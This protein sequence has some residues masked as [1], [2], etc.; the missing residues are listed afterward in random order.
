MNGLGAVDDTEFAT[1]ILFILCPQT[2]YT[3]SRKEIRKWTHSLQEVS[4]V[5]GK[6]RVLKGPEDRR[7]VVR[8]RRTW[9]FKRTWPLA[10]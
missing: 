6:G 1:N 10:K 5:A 4:T 8:V 7:E 3:L 9:V 2:T